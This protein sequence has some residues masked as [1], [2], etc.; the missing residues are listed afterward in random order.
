MKALLSI[1]ALVFLSA[2]I[3]PVFAD[4]I[5][6]EPD[7][8]DG[9]W[10]S[11]ECTNWYSNRPHILETLA[12]GYVDETGTEYNWYHDL[13]WNA[14]QQLSWNELAEY[15]SNTNYKNNMIS[16]YIKKHNLPNT[17]ETYDELGQY[18]YY[19]LQHTRT[20]VVT[21]E[22]LGDGYWPTPD[23]FV[24]DDPTLSVHISEDDDILSIYG[25]VTY[26]DYLEQNTTGRFEIKD[27]EGNLILNLDDFVG[28]ITGSFHK[29]IDLTELPLGTYTVTANYEGLVTEPK[30]F[31]AYG[32]IGETSFESDLTYDDNRGVLSISGYYHPAKDI[33]VNVLFDAPPVN[34]DGN[35]LHKG[36]GFPNMTRYADGTFEA[37]LA[38][39]D[40]I[41]DRPGTLVV[42]ASDPTSREEMGFSAYGVFGKATYGIDFMPN[43]PNNPSPEPQPA[44]TVS[45]DKT[46]Y[47]D[48]EELLVSGMASFDEDVQFVN[49]QIFTPGKTNFADFNTVSINSDGTYSA[50][51]TVGGPTWT[52]DGQYVV[53]ATY[54]GSVETTIN[55]TSEPE[56]TP[57]QV[58]AEIGENDIGY[59]PIITTFENVSGTSV[60]FQVQSFNGTTVFE[61]DR[62]VDETHSGTL[63]WNHINYHPTGIYTISV[64]D[65]VATASTTVNWVNPE[66]EIPPFGDGV[67]V[68]TTSN[69]AVELVLQ[70]GDS[71]IRTEDNDRIWN[72]QIA[73]TPLG[74]NI[75]RANGDVE[76]LYKLQN[77]FL[78][79]GLSDVTFSYRVG[80]LE[81][82][83][84]ISGA[85]TC[86]HEYT[87]I[88]V[89]PYLDAGETLYVNIKVDADAFSI[90]IEMTVLWAETLVIGTQEPPPE[91]TPEI[92]PTNSTYSIVTPSDQPLLTLSQQWTSYGTNLIGELNGFNLPPNTTAI[93]DVEFPD[94]RD[95]MH[96]EISITQ[97]GTLN[98][99]WMFSIYNPEGT[100]N[101]VLDTTQYVF[102]CDV[103]YDG[104]ALQSDTCEISTVKENGDIEDTT[105]VPVLESGSNGG[106]NYSHGGGSG[107]SGSSGGSSAPSSG[108]TGE[109]STYS[110]QNLYLAL[111][112]IFAELAQR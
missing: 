7:C 8:P 98:M 92:I 29:E 70:P 68:V 41:P 62:A 5:H 91:P 27:S 111:S 58:T 83:S 38:L 54:N 16:D 1:I 109:Y 63:Y 44:I 49:V 13:P 106:P 90:P 103:V 100:Y 60:L 79:T 10:T 17:I 87:G 73:A 35:G 51:F 93:I 96:F 28:Q 97:D 78:T 15:H 52:S 50:V 34:I 107:S 56:P 42:T 101:V 12:P 65:D 86:Q 9:E 40:H 6:E 71:Y 20:F 66:P 48:G 22:V 19:Q 105:T 36:F 11:Q 89:I 88:V 85:D 59:N 112:E 74:D 32:L 4:H 95:P 33:H 76:G 53:K 46:S 104:N 80:S 25:Y 57:L 23:E 2:T 14:V 45:T 24:P 37:T 64:T 67:L 94:N 72:G 84:C 75:L 47:T 77:Y 108:N 81:Q 69:T 31:E 26:Q 21:D 39:A 102:E 43:S 99:P 82:A 3:I 55:Y 30:S 61:V 110:N 18:T